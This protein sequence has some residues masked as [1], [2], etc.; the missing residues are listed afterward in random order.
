MPF[1]KINWDALCL[2]GREEYM[3]THN[4]YTCW[5]EQASPDSTQGDCTTRVFNWA[6]TAVDDLLLE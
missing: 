6:L 3:I 2:P 4:L 1:A 5:E